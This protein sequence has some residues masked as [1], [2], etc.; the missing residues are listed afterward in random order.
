MGSCT[1]NNNAIAPHSLIRT[2]IK[3]IQKF[4]GLKSGDVLPRDSSREETTIGMVSKKCQ[5]LDAKE[6]F[7]FFVSDRRCIRA[8]TSQKHQTESKV[9]EKRSSEIWIKCDGC[10]C[11]FLAGSEFLQEAV[12]ILDAHPFQISSLAQ[13]RAHQKDRPPGSSQA[14]TSCSPEK[15][16]TKKLLS[17]KATNKKPIRP[18][19]NR[20]V[21]C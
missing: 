12:P 6:Q 18:S 15:G 2:Q 5:H 4:D 19:N 20:W 9:E 16:S 3:N 13:R 17:L 8:S 11:W 14:R 21:D 10:V 1:S 7:Q